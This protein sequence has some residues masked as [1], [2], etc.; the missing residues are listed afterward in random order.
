MTWTYDGS[1]SANDRDAVR[2]LVTDTD[3]TD[4]LVTDE[5]IAWALAE[6]PN[7]Y[8]A[9]SVVA[10]QIARQF[11]RKAYS[12]T[13]GDLKIDLTARASEFRALSTALSEQAETDVV[14]KAYV[15]GTSHD[16]KED[17]RQDQD[18][19]DPLFTRRGLYEEREDTDYRTDAPIRPE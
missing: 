6:N 11:A 9:A 4:Q 14:P 5:E 15:G 7:V 3:T 10:M 2:F 16:E 8:I 12:K 13:V 19:I 18:R 17:H 1:P